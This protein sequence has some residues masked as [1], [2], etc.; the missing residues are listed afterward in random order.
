M[1]KILSIVFFEV[2]RTLQLFVLILKRL[3]THPF[4]GFDITYNDIKH[5]YEVCV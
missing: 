1:K 5:R 3:I 2:S 4:R